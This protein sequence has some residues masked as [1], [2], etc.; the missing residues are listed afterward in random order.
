MEEKKIV[1]KQTYQLELITYEDD[2][3]KLSRQ[4]DG[5]TAW[6]LLGLLEKIQMDILQILADD[7]QPDIVERKVV[8]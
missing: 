5:F 2:T 1:S 8:K 7:V 4:N 6:E 3:Q